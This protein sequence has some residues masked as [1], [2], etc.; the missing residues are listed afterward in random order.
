MNFGHSSPLYPS[1]LKGAACGDRSQ[2]PALPH[3]CFIQRFPTGSSSLYSGWLSY[4]SSQFKCHLDRGHLWSPCSLIASTPSIPHLGPQLYS[5]IEHTTF[6]SWHIFLFII[7]C[8]SKWMIDVC[9]SHYTVKSLRVY[10]IH[11]RLTF[12]NSPNIHSSPIMGLAL[13]IGIL[14]DSVSNCWLVIWIR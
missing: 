12:I 7:T 13:H 1:W 4:P 2:Q 5:I 6:S 14:V 9:L 3:S 11:I 8:F 10:L